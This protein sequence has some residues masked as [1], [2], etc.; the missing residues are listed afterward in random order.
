MFW[1]IFGGLSGSAL[2]MMAG[3][4]ASHIAMAYPAGGGLAVALML[5]LVAIASDPAGETF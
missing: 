3:F 5:W 1:A 4:D 2:A